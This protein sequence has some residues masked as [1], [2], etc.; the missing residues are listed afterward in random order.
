MEKNRQKVSII[1][2]FSTHGNLLEKC[3]LSLKNQSYENIEVIVIYNNPKIPDI[4]NKKLVESLGFIWLEESKIGSYGARNTGIKY[5]NGSIIAF[6]D[7]DCVADKHWIE[8]AVLFM[9][10]NIDVG[11]VGGRIKMIDNLEMEESRIFTLY[12]MYEELFDFNQKY[13]I[14]HNHSGC[15]SNLFVRRN[16]FFSDGCLSAVGL[17]ND[18]LKSMGDYDFVNKAYKN[19]FKILYCDEALV[20]HPFRESFNAF[21]QKQRRIA[22]G[23]YLLLQKRSPN[24]FSL[25]FNI[26]SSNIINSLR[27]IKLASKNRNGLSLKIRFFVLIIFVHSIALLEQFLIIFSGRIKNE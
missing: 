16:I 13:F 26:I 10:D 1:I 17:F 19:G 9:S 14:E 15:T 22:G 4:E 8:K 20:F 6:I 18:D 25:I 5:S 11:I 21:I 24:I 7:A 12:K 3:L 23:V 2:P 27:Y